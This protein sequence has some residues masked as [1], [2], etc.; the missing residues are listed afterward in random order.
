[1]LYVAGIVKFILYGFICTVKIIRE[2]TNQR[3]M[4]NQSQRN[5]KGGIIQN[6]MS[7]AI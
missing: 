2:I 1:M 3:K 6:S 7:V 5:N 4:Y